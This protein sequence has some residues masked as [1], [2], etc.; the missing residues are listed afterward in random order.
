MRKLIIIIICLMNGFFDTNYNWHYFILFY[1]ILCFTD[2]IQVTN[3]YHQNQT[4]FWYNNILN[5][6]HVY[7]LTKD[8]KDTI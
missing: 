5:F 3:S 6:V 4:G 2:K 1:F 8:T 7:T